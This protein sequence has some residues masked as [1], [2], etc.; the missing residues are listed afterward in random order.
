MNTHLAVRRIANPCESIEINV[1]PFVCLLLTQICTHPLI[2]P[3]FFIYLHEVVGQVIEV[4]QVIHIVP[5]YLKSKLLH[6]ASITFKVSSTK[7]KY[8]SSQ[9]KNIVGVPVPNHLSNQRYQHI[10]KLNFSNRSNTVRRISNKVDM[11]IDRHKIK[12]FRSSFS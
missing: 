9:W 10:L 5:I 3:K 6:I 2:Y 11:R 12:Y 8:Y 7:Y 4:V 1:C